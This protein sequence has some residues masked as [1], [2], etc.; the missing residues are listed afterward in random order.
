MA[1]VELTPSRRGVVVL[2]ASN[3]SRGLVRLVATT[4]CRSPGPLD[5]FVV[6]GHGRGY[7]VSTRVWQRRLPSILSSGLW[8]ALD[9]ERPDR[10]LAVITDVGN[11][12]LYGLGVTA[13]ASAVRE[14][15]TRLADRGARLA[16]TGLPLAGIDGVGPVRYRL[17]RTLYVPGCLLRLAELKAATRWLD[18][19]LQAI[20]ADTGATFLE[21]PAEWYGFDALHVRRPHLDALWHRVCDAWTLPPVADAPRA[22]FA[23]WATLGSKAAE[24]RS[25]GRIPRLTRQPVIDRDVFRMWMY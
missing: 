21:Q 22:T 12:L 13:V 18:E 11:E 15:A 4:R 10:P 17:L 5:L 2:G 24:V 16:I 20:A 14:A 8:R 9:R 19:E 1:A 7:G 25:L 6:A 23:D 3:V